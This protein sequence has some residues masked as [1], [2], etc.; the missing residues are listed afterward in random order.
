LIIKKIGDMVGTPH[1]ILLLF[2][3]NRDRKLLSDFLESLGHRVKIP[4]PRQTP[5]P[6]WTEIGI[7]I[8][9]EWAA[10]RYGKS[11][12]EKKQKSDVFI[13]LLI[14]K[15][16]KCT[17]SRWLEFGFDDALHMPFTKAELQ[18]RLTTFLRIREQSDELKRQ[19]EATLKALIES[20]SDHIFMLSRDGVFLV[21]NN[22]MT[23]FFSDDIHNVVGRFLQ[24]VYPPALSSE[25]C[26]MMKQVFT[27]K[28]SLTF[29]KIMPGEEADFYHQYTLYPIVRGDIV[30]AV[31]GI[32]R[33]ITALKQ[34]EERASRSVR[35]KDALLRELYHRT[36]NNMQVIIAMLHL[37]SQAVTDE[38][39][40]QV[41]R[42]VEN[43]IKS[44]SL[45]HQKLYQAKDL[46]RIELKDYIRDLVD[47]LVRSYKKKSQ[48][49]TINLDMESVSV[50]IDVAIPC[51]L[52]INELISNSFKHAFNERGK[53]VITIHLRCF[54]DDEIEI[55]A[56]DDGEGMAEDFDIREGD[57]LGLQSVIAMVEH[58]LRG[59][60]EMNTEKGTK[61]RIRFRNSFRSEND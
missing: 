42:E 41:F 50:N 59:T 34:A 8:T 44:M 6:E 9:D 11:L 1:T 56:A 54:Q 2:F 4:D 5:L 32:C 28:K 36:K 35:E 31:G 40:L 55:T 52:V 23:S 38:N 21:S 18:A 20:S 27:Y 53:G 46:S 60:L 48:L 57:T 37:Q 15:K 33:D 14:A 13:A 47:L 19:R 26:R 17:T 61:F 51:G 10:R 29:E 12:V 58:Q 25:L 49:I 24:D 43:R 3:S 39:L 30:Q 22:K 7:I 45:V 16:G